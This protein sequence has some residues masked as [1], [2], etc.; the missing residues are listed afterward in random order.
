M[1]NRRAETNTIAVPITVYMS[2]C[3]TFSVDSPKVGFGEL[4]FN[5]VDCFPT[6]PDICFRVDGYD[7][8]CHK[9]RTTKLTQHSSII[10]PTPPILSLKLI[11]ELYCVFVCSPRHFSV[12]A[13]IILKPYW[14]TT[15]VKESCCS[16]SPAPQSLLYTTFPMIYLSTSCI[17][18]TLTTQR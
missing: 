15:S 8:L 16:P 18:S 17:T 9:V 11:S 13:V 4:P 6:Y 3:V 2:P 5:R 1:K 10:V 14:R 7:F 12:D